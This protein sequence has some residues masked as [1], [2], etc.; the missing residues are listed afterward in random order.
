MKRTPATSRHCD[1]FT[2]LEVVLALAILAGSVVALGQVIHLA[3]RAA[4]ETNHLTQAEL[5]AASKLAEITS[6]IVAL[7]PVTNA[8]LDIGREWTYSLSVEPSG[9]DGVIAVRVTVVRGLG[10]ADASEQFSLV[11]WVL[12]EQ[13]GQTSAAGGPP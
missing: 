7:D 13:T 1:A 4:S 5:L 6:G 9:I 2:L 3:A 10:G 11:R 8:S 12:D